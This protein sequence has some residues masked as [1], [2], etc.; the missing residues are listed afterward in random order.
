MAAL[1]VGHETTRDAGLRVG[2]RLTIAEPTMG[3]AEA[4]SVAQELS[5]VTAEERE[6]LVMEHLPVV[7]FIAR[8]LHERL[9]QHVELED[10]ISAGVIG[11]I[12]ACGRFDR[13]RQVQFKSYA[14]FRIRGAILDALR[15]LDWSPRELRRRGRAVEEATRV[16]TLRLGRAPAAEELARAMELSLGDLQQLLG[17]LKGLEIES[18][19]AERTEEAGDEELDYV[20]A[21]P[22]ESPLL[23]CLEGETRQQLMD[24]M[25]DLPEKERLVLTLYYFEDL[26]MKE[27]GQALGVVESRV[28]QIH[29]MAMRRMRAAMGVTVIPMEPVARARRTPQ[30]M[31]SAA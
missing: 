14:Q 15:L 8:R 6:R 12:D 11:L 5:G 2:A 10:L 25:E 30:R 31:R 24:A 1:A 13:T 7:R 21:A 16:L 17:E 29:S 3:S 9:P 22:G 20:E 27:I 23:R 4:K 26:T 19:N 28:S 18:L